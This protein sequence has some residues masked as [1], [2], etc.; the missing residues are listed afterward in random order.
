MRVANTSL[1]RLRRSLQSK[2]FKVELSYATKIPL[3]SIAL[4]L[5]G[6]AEDNNSQDALRVLDI[7][8]RQQAADRGCLLVRQSFFHDDSRNFT[9]I[10]GGVHGLRGFHSSFRPTQ[11]GLSLNM[12]IAIVLG[13]VNFM[14]TGLDSYLLVV[15][16]F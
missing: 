8:L 12:G 11:G 3:R 7:I 4:A 16:L 5:K 14:F 2:T 1:K 13:G 15:L 9:D 10:G 6:A